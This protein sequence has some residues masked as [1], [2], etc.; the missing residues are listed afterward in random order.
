MYF[1]SNQINASFAFYSSGSFTFSKPSL[2]ACAEVPSAKLQMSILLKVRKRSFMKMFKS[3]A[4][5]A[6]P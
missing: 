3:K 5:T 1:F 2:R 4:S 6:E